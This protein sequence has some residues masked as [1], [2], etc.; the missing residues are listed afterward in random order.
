MARPRW[1]CALDAT[2]G[3][4]RAW[5]IRSRRAAR[6]LHGRGAAEDDVEGERNVA[7]RHRPPDS[8]RL[9]QLRDVLQAPDVGGG[10]GVTG[11]VNQ[12]ACAAARGTGASGAS[13]CSVRG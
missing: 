11:G 8:V 2:P 12:T 1:V 5:K 4:R 10:K 7:Q 9:D 13:R 3:R 6:L